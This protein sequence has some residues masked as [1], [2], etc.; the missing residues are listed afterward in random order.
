[1]SIYASS[2]DTSSILC[3]LY[4]LFF[5][6]DEWYSLFLIQSMVCTT[7]LPVQVIEF[8]LVVNINV[9]NVYTVK[10]QYIIYHLG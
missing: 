4:I 6:Y 5:V 8:G 7:G 9:S 1:M 2:I 3:L 10:K